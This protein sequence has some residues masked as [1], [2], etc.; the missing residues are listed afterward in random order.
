MIRLVKWGALGLVAL[1][2]LGF[3]VFGAHFP[4]YVGTGFHMASK[5]GKDRIPVEFELRRSESLIEGILPEIRACKRVIAEEEVAVEQLR[6]QIA[7]LEERQVREKGKILALRD[8]LARETPLLT[9]AGVP[10]SRAGVERDLERVFDVHRNEAELLESKRR[11]LES[12]E[13]SL[14]AARHKLDVVRT[15]K[16][17]LETVVQNLH[18]KLREV[19]ALE[20]TA[21]FSL[22]TS[23]L[24]KAKQVLAECER[25]LAVAEKVIHQDA[26]ELPVAEFDVAGEPRDLLAEIDRYF[27]G[28]PDA[29]QPKPAF[30]S[31]TKSY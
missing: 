7:G 1:G 31:S 27:E 16:A 9:V 20:A 17:R 21:T 10:A 25:R 8:A 23:N 29:P 30:A 6:D 19:Q 12:R 15:E 28:A 22:D 13:K 4:S 26:A 5:A 3:A 18:A 24:A 11:L 2:V 14:V